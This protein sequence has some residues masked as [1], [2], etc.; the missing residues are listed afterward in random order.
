MNR[1]VA[2]AT[3]SDQSI[4]SV[5]RQ[6]LL[7]RILSKSIQPGDRVNENQLASEF[8][9][10]RGPIRE[11]LRALEQ[12]HLVEI[13]HNR[14]VFVRKLDIADVLHLYDV[15]AGLAYMAGKLLARRITSEQ[16]SELYAFH[17]AMEEARQNKDS[18]AYVGL[19]EKFHAAL[20][21]FTGN[22]RLIEWSRNIDQEM[23]LFLRGGSF[24]PSRLRASN[25]QHLTIIQRIDAGDA[26]GAAFA[27]EDHVTTGKVR[28]LDSLIV[29]MGRAPEA[30]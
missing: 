27:F 22:P 24:G 7:D 5:V 15:R 14:G 28:A 30:S 18:L 19:N 16:V 8:K 17:E 9:V 2:I 6:A 26:E 1:T 25:E 29:S 13:V 21:S 10:S 12:A 3:D 20:M 4:T 11:A 23:R